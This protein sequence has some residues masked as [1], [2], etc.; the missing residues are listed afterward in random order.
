MK[1]HLILQGHCPICNGEDLEYDSDPEFNGD[2]VEFGFSCPD[3][4]NTG[5]EISVVSFCGFEVDDGEWYEELTE[6]ETK[7]G[8]QKK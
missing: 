5:R 7:K 3:C 1:K 2:N 4:G 6:V 8:K